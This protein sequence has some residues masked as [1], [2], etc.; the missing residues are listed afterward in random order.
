MKINLSKSYSGRKLKAIEMI[1]S[2]KKQ[3]QLKRNGKN[4]QYLLSLLYYYKV[5]P[6]LKLE[7]T[8]TWQAF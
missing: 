5:L 4:K 7:K 2:A 8:S 6:H 1:A 3:S